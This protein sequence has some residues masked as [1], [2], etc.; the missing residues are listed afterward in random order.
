MEERLKEIIKQTLKETS[1]TGAGSSAG[2]FT[3]GEGPQIATKYA[4]RAKKPKDLVESTQINE[5]HVNV[6][7][8]INSLNI[9]DPAL[10]KHISSRII[11]FDKIESKLNELIPL[12]QKAKS[13][14][15]EYYKKNPNFS[16]LYGTDLINSYL[17]DIKTM[18][19]K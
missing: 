1:A 18:L 10:K 2:S 9:T 5:V 17:D 15:L 12:L 19:N 14:T 6:E 7:E 3:P 16:I 8:Y 4:F 13:E 11:G